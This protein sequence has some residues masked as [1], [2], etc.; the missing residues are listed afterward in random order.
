MNRRKILSYIR[1]AIITVILM[2]LFTIGIVID[3]KNK[4]KVLPSKT[5][6]QEYQKQQVIYLID[7]YKYEAKTNNSSYMLCMKL[8]LLYESIENY[9]LAEVEYKNAMAK[10][11]Y[12]TFEPIFML[13][14]LYVKVGEPDK[15][16]EL[17]DNIKDYPD[18]KLIK[19]KAQMYK[20][21]AEKYLEQEKYEN[22]IITYKNS[23]FYIKKVHLKNNKPV[24]E[25]N[26][27]L[28]KA[29]IG[30]SNIYLQQ[31]KYKRALNKAIEGEELTKSIE[32][33]NYI[34]TIAK[35][36]N[37]DFALIAYDKL[38]KLDKNLINYE[39]YS[40]CIEKVMN[41]ATK[42]NDSYS[43]KRYREKLKRLDNF[44]TRSIIKKSDV[45]VN[46]ISYKY[47]KQSMN[48][49]E[50]IT[51]SYSITNNQI[52]PLNRLYILIKVYSDGELKKQASNKIVGKTNIL[53]SG[54]RSSTHK[55][56]LHIP[57]KEAYTTTATVKIDVYLTKHDKIKP[58]LIDSV[59][60]PKM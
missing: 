53:E 38:F 20:K 33:L 32:L 26:K 31:G 18:K 28:T 12:R 52:Y 51:V 13:S 27:G 6:V 42:A 48:M 11:P 47:K 46:F 60:I 4:A 5:T 16:I 21:I 49:G 43:E 25:I 36:K 41:M 35:D 34:A 14:E 40:D 58:I 45:T 3:T 54:G 1:T 17:V 30:L 37:P 9:E 8:G 29:Y 15:A 7:K 39:D 59:L 55:M 56:H 24:T 44:I 2:M 22:A 19:Q 57:H 10:A 50:D 23:L